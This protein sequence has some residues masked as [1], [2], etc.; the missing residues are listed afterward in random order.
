MFKTRNSTRD[1]NAPV[2]LTLDRR[3]DTGTVSEHW[4]PDVELF[5]QRKGLLLLGPELSRFSM[6][7]LDPM[8][9]GFQR[10]DTKL[11]FQTDPW[12]LVA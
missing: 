5:V 2:F 6:H 10:R 3:I 8:R 1:R 11:G 4:L 12:L 7:A 9:L